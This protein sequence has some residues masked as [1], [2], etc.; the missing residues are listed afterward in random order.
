M[1]QCIKHSD[2]V[3]NLM[4]R[5][6]D[7]KNFSFEDVHVNG[8]RQVAKLCREHGVSKLI[9][10]SSLNARLDSPSAFLRSKAKGELAVLEE[11]PEATIVRPATMY[12]HEDRFWN[13][14][15]CIFS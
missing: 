6:Y 3:Y 12:G 2:V 5:N 11:F 1:I 7:T 13:K 9:H 15:G 10:V 14:M 8:A 4:G